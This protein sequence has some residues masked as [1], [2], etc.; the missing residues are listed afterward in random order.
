MHIWTEIVSKCVFFDVWRYFSN[1]PLHCLKIEKS[2]NE[3]KSAATF[4]HQILQYKIS[5]RFPATT[6]L[7]TG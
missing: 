1:N 5:H 2:L 7:F 4:C 6:K 3:D